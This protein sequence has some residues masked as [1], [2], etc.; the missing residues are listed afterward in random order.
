MC[1]SLEGWERSS[2]SLGW[3]VGMD[4]SVSRGGLVEVV[5]CVK[6]L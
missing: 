1:F 6:V 3:D 2:G 5:V 4:V